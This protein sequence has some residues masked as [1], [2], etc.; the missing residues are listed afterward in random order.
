MIAVIAI[1]ALLIALVAPGLGTLSGRRLQ[2]TAD[3]LAASLELAR[4]RTVMTGVPHRLHLDLDA[5]TWRLEW[6]VSD[7]EE[8]GEEAVAPE[9]PL[10]L[11]GRAKLDLHPP[12]GEERSFRPMPG[13]LGRD[14]PLDDSLAFAGVQTDE[15]FANR[16]EAVVEFASDGSA[17]YTEI[18]LDDESGRRLAIEVLPLA[19][20]VRVFDAKS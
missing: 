15:G 1:L 10:D 8:R 19:E 12:R 17:A 16:G 20:S 13:K 18:L 11:E 2:S 14:E 4:Q 6:W 5:A 9:P 7:A 3:R